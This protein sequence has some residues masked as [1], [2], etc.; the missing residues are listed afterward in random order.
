MKANKMYEGKQ[1]RR[2][3]SSSLEAHQEL[4]ENIDKIHEVPPGE[5]MFKG[6]ALLLWKYIMRSKP[7][8]EWT[9]SDLILAYKYVDYDIT[10]KRG[11][12]RLAELI[13]GGADL[14]DPESY[15]CEY[16]CEIEKIKTKQMVIFRALGFA[17]AAQRQPYDNKGNDKSD[18]EM[19]Q[20]ELLSSMRGSG[21]G[22]MPGFLAKQ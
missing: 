9:T 17:R 10:I 5:K 19:T 20:F 3:S 4:L 21:K 6:N 8:K 15:A 16:S 2:A 7:Y 14:L 11:E 22:G 1:N 13:E 18:A 12:D